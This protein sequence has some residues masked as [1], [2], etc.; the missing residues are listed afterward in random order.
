MLTRA[1]LAALVLATL[2]AWP[3]LAH[4]EGEVEWSQYQ[5]GPGHPGTLSGAPEPPYR[6]IWRFMAPEGSLSGAVVVGDVAIAVGENAVYAV[7][8]ATGAIAWQVPRDGGRL[9]MPAV[10]AVGEQQLLVYLDGP[11]EDPDG[12]SPSPTASASPTPSPTSSA[13]PSPTAN[14][15]A[16]SELVAVDLADR[17]EVWRITLGD[18]ARAGVTVD[19][20]RAYVADDEGTV[21]AIDLGTGAVAWTADTPGRVESAPAAAEGTVVV[22]SRDPDEQRSQ[23]TA[24]GEET[25]ERAWSFSTEA[26][27]V[28]SSGV[29]LV[30]ATVVFG[31]ADRLV[32]G[33]AADDG[34][35]RWDALTLTL[36]SPVTAPAFQPGNVYVADASGGV[37]RLDPADGSRDWEHQTNDLVVRSSPVIAGRFVL[38]GLNGGRLVA[39]DAEDGDQVWESAASQGLVGQ[40]ALSHEAVVVVKGGK[41]PGLI[42][43]EHDPEGVLVEVPSPTILDPAKMIGAFAAAA[44]IAGLAILLPFRLLRSRIKP[45]FTREGGLEE[46]DADAGD[47]P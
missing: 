13:S 1:A 18:A 45:A 11:R 36:F 34:S 10:G 40:I 44:V 32:R 6:E 39:F 38:V 31:S 21:S 43:F 29:S 19:G 7:D 8:L 20:E 27:A 46:P 35:L 47:E 41:E 25:G 2:A 26:G 37:Y 22:V 16:V 23:V 4:E 3:A 28:A 9:A 17:S 30:D 42:A 24:F 14:A 33:L 15:P 5:G 12:A